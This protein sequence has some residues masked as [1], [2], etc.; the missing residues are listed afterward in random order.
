MSTRTFVTA[1]VA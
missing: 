1:P